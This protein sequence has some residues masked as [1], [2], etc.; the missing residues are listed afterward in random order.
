[1]IRVFLLLMGLLTAFKVPLFAQYTF[2]PLRLDDE[3]DNHFL[4]PAVTSE[5]D[6]NLLYTWASWSPTRL[7]TCGQRMTPDGDLLGPRIIY[8]EGVPTQT[9]CPA[10]ATVIKLADGR[11]VQ[12]LAHG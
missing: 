3:Q 11:E 4:Y 6:G 9:T 10:Q 2:G 1:M 8:E 5:P 12:L 7:S